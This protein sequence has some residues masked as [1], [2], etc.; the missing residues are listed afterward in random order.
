LISLRGAYSWLPI[1][2]CRCGYLFGFAARM[3]L[4][5]KQLIKKAKGDEKF[6]QIY[7]IPEIE[8]LIFKTPIVFILKPD[9]SA[10]PQ[11]FEWH[12]LTGGP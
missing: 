3:H 11:G 2:R 4:K 12:P 9:S 1:K 7:A 6:N 10:P 8:Q 5:T